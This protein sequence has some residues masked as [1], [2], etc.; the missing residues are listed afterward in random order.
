[1]LNSIFEEYGLSQKVFSIGFDNASANTASIPDLIKVCQSLLNGNFFHIRC[2]CHILNLAVQ[3]GLKVLNL[4]L[5]TIRN[6]IMLLWA[7][8]SLMRA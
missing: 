2:A 7:R 3:D 8:T 4:H 1:M 5:K 6:A